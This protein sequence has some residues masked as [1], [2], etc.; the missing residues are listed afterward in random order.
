MKPLIPPVCLCHSVRREE[1]SNI[2]LSQ[3]VTLCKAISKVRSGKSPKNYR[4]V[5]ESAFESHT[6]ATALPSSSSAVPSRTLNSVMVMEQASLKPEASEGN[7][8]H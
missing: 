8:L 2:I 3:I 7:E 5:Q 4:V 6:R 1:A